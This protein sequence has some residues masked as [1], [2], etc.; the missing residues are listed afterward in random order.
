[1]KLTETYINNGNVNP[2]TCIWFRFNSYYLAFPFSNP[3]VANQLRLVE[4]FKSSAW[5]LWLEDKTILILTKQEGKEL[6]S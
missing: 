1:M 2:K 6:C 4:H 5:K 3:T